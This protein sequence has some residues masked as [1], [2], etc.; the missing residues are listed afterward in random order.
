M[1]WILAGL[2]FG[3]LAFCVPLLSPAILFVFIAAFLA[4]ISFSM[5]GPLSLTLF[6]GLVPR[7]R[8]GLAIGVYGAA[9]DIGIIIGPALFSVAL[10]GFGVSTAFIA[11]AV[12][13]L[14]GL[15]LL[16][17]KRP[18]KHIVSLEEQTNIE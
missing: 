10:V 18:K 14:A 7:S 11:I 15:G 8:K 4:G 12:I 6:V 9:E 17:T 2:L 1:R 3:A 13:N 5:L 16:A